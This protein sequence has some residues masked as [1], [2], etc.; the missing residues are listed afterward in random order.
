MTILAY[1]SGILT[2]ALC[3]ALVIGFSDTKRRR[4]VKGRIV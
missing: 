3:E 4:L 1:L 2:Y